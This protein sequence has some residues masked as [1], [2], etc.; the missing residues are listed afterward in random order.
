MSTSYITDEANQGTLFDRKPQVLFV[1]VKIPVKLHARPD[2]FHQRENELARLLQEAKAGNVIGW[3]QSLSDAEQ[4]GSQ[5]LLHQRIDITTAD[6]E[7]TRTTLHAALE[8]LAVPSGTEIHYTHA[9]QMLM[10]VYARGH[11]CLD[12]VAV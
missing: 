7:T 11:W 4:D 2:P 6:I 8:M 1:Y 12:Q 10:D 5:H 3:G 9:G